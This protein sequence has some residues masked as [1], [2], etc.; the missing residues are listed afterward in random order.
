MSAKRDENLNLFASC[1]ADF[2]VRTSA[3]PGSA[4]GSTASAPAFG[5][6]SRESSASFS[7]DG[8]S[9][10]TSRAAKR[11]GCARC[12]ATCK[13]L[14]TVR[15]PS[16]FLPLTSGHRTDGD[17]SSSWASPLARDSNGRTRPGPRETLADQVW[18]TPITTDAKGSRRTGLS[19]GS[20]TG[21]TLTDA[22]RWPTPT[23]ASYGTRNNGTPGDGRERY[24]TAGAPSL[25][26]IARSEGGALNPDWVEALMG[27]PR[28]WTAGLR[29]AALRKLRT[30]PL[31]LF[32]TDA[33]E[34]AAS[35]SPR[36]VTRS[37]LSARRSSDG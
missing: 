36:W 15:P 32:A 25:E 24:E 20:H 1:A 16:R 22:V 35:G 37:S 3:S 29:G 27:F 12:G 26:T 2:P 17:G 18:P 13:L 10:K 4:E 6:T 5:A 28:G 19:P 14:A 31:A 21:E 34:L 9:L 7:R 11:A 8:S 23:A 30:S 33:A